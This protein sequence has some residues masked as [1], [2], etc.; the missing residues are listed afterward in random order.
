MLSQWQHLWKVLIIL[1]L[2][3]ALLFL[4][5]GLLSN[6]FDEF[7][8]SLFMRDS[9][10]TASLPFYAGLVPQLE[11]ILWS[12]SLA[13][14]MFMYVVLSRFKTEFS[15]PRQFFLQIGIVTAVLLFDKVF[16]FHGEVAPKYLHIDKLIVLSLYLLMMIFLL[17]SNRVEILSS[18][19]LLFFLAI[20]MLG[21]SIVLDVLPL[22]ALHVP[23]SWQQ[24]RY[25][26]EDGLKFAGIATWLTYVSRLAIRQLESIRLPGRLPGSG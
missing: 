25:F 11:N 17:V 23:I 24:L 19:Y 5:I 26:L 8:L 6:I 22:E 9:V 16:I 4:M 21:T 1:Y 18:E 15:S 20:G 12:A 10:T 3:V 14:C 7:T 2:P 13:I